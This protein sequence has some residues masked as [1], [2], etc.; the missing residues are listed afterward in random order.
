[1][2]KTILFF[3]LTFLPFAGTAQENEE[4]RKGWQ[5]LTDAKAPSEKIEAYHTLA[6]YYASYPR[7][8][9]TNRDSAQY[10]LDKAG[11]INKT[12]QSRKASGQH[13]LLLAKISRSRGDSVRG[14]QYARKAAAIATENKLRVLEGEAWL[15]CSNF[16]AEEQK[17]QKL[18]LLEKSVS[19][20]R[21]AKKS[22]P[23][24]IALAQLSI[25]YTYN[26]R[27]TEAQSCAKEALSVCKSIGEK[28]LSYPYLAMAT[29][30]MEEGKYDAA[31]KSGLKA[32][33]YA[34]LNR[35]NPDLLA[36]IYTNLGAAY[37]YSVY[38]EQSMRYLQKGIDY[39]DASKD[40]DRIYNNASLIL[41][42]KTS[43]EPG[44]ALTYYNN[45]VR[46]Y[47][48]ND[49]RI[50]INAKKMLLWISASAGNLA[51]AETTCVELMELVD[52]HREKVLKTELLNVYSMII[53]YSLMSGHTKRGRK[54]LELLKV[55]PEVPA[56]MYCDIYYYDSSISA[57]EGNYLNAIAAFQK[58]DA[59]A[60]S[61]T[62]ASKS[63]MI[64]EL[65]VKFAVQQKDNKILAKS[66]D[67]TLLTK[68][69]EIQAALINRK[70]ITNIVITLFVFLFAVLALVL[71][72]SFK[73]RQR[74]GKN[75][76]NKN[77]EIEDKNTQLNVLVQ[78]REWLLKE[79]HQRVKN[80]LQIIM[81]LLKS[82]SE[83]LHDEG[84]II[85]IRNSQHRVHSMALIHHKLFSTSD[86]PDFINIRAYIN[87]LVEYLRESFDVGDTIGF[88]VAVED[89]E[90]EVAMAVPIGLI[91]NEAVTNSI[92]YAFPQS[93]TGHIR[94]SLLC[95]GAN[96]FTLKI[97][98]DG[99]G[100]PA[101]FDV[102]KAKSLGIKLIRGL[103]RDLEGSFT[104]LNNN[105]TTIQIEFVYNLKFKHK[106]S[107]Y[108]TEGTYSRGPVY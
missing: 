27:F 101:D 23:F 36:D 52:Q 72:R 82:Q 15:E 50:L 59:L 21:K 8:R 97:A 26:E 86:Q 78:E 85:A 99:I 13:Y 43:Q 11:R 93:R 1:M 45:F 42:F 98:D 92:K 10:Y 65:Q 51:A 62:M 46:K 41:V 2:K 29:M 60:D 73:S 79:I 76:E 38:W 20:F 57:Q 75:L 83:S 54:Y 61:L 39:Y 25:A 17:Q 70:H 88:D 95:S 18:G 19:A 108:E 9:R 48:P 102:T 71:Y 4:L 64:S 28:N 55:L 63:K 16:Y 37:Y 74:A 81:S 89:M 44:A 49:V 105:G 104:M 7:E 30:H 91:L 34:A 47:P 58:S 40:M 94:V 107:E 24:V 31:I 22:R 53:N 56:I 33:S 103:S 90:M 66:K 5:L 96:N 35:N 6:Y 69:K 3:F 32:D 84:A 106:K 77:I 100:Y 67:I 12:V 68:Q 14:Q 87:E 80:N